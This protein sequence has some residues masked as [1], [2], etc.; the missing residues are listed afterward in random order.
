MHFTFYGKRWK[1]IK[2]RENVSSIYYIEQGSVF[3]EYTMFYE[4]R[5]ISELRE[6][7][8]ISSAEASC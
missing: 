6:S 4:T 8:V 7:S 1:Q 2:A 3:K 5:S